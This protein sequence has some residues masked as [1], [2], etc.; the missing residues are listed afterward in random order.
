MIVSID[1]CQF[2]VLQ[3][4]RLQTEISKQCLRLFYL[5]PMFQLGIKTQYHRITGYERQCSFC[6]FLV[7]S[8]FL[9]I[10]LSWLETFVYTPNQN[11]IRKNTFIVKVKVLTMPETQHF[12]WMLFLIG[13]FCSVFRWKMDGCSLL[14]MAIKTD[15]RT[16]IKFTTLLKL[17]K[18]SLPET[19]GISQSGVKKKEKEKY[20]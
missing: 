6:V 16:N 15:S 9:F 14:E 11:T 19:I 1:D 3:R 20:Q 12:S 5:F 18:T 7:L 17:K 8:F 4:V 13:R 2:F 10:T